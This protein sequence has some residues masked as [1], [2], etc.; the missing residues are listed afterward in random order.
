[1]KPLLW[2]D[3]ET[4]GL[5]PE[6]EHILEIAMVATDER[7]EIESEVEFLL[8]CPLALD[9]LRENPF[10]LKMHHENGLI[11]DRAKG[12][13]VS[14]HVAEDALIDLFSAFAFGRPMAGSTPSFD[15]S[16]L[17]RRMPR[18][19]RVFSHR[20]FDMSTLRAFLELEKPKDAK[21]AHRAMKDILADLRELKGLLAGSHH[22]IPEILIKVPDD[23][24]LTAG[25][26][27]VRPVGDEKWQEVM[28]CGGAL[29]GSMRNGHL[30][31]EVRYKP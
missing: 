6:V 17:V 21:S 25:V 16:F 20:H 29:A 10:V 14:L 30:N 2:I 4:T 27:Q 5:D 23:E 3:I 13:L 1:M 24:I 7:G 12:G 31:W 15:R 9:R 11:E 26:H 8:E 22:K 18:L 28:S 19:E